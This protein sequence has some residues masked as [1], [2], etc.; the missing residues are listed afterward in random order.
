MLL[1]LIA[2]LAVGTFSKKLLAPHVES[3]LA[4]NLAAGGIRLSVTLFIAARLFN[5]S[6]FMFRPVWLV[7]STAILLSGLLIYFWPDDS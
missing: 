7:I 5:L 3:E 1:P 2:V 6:R 4:S